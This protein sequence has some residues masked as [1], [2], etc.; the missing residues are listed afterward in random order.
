MRYFAKSH[1]DHQTDGGMRHIENRLSLERIP[2]NHGLVRAI[3]LGP[4]GL[5][6]VTINL[7]QH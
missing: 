1:V 5:G 6:D 2:F 4:N 3:L 7:T